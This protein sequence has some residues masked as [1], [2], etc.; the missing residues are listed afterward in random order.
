LV[1]SPKPETSYE[2]EDKGDTSGVGPLDHE[3]PTLM[4]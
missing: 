1:L 4:V 2:E 3:I